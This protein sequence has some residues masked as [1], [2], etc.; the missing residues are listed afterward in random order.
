VVTAVLTGLVVLG[1]ALLGL[2]MRATYGAQVTGDEPQYLL[3]AISLAEDGSLDIDDELDEQRWRDFHE[4]TLPTQTEVLPDGRQLSPHNAGLPALLALP[5]SL[6]GWVGAK[7]A[8][9][10]VFAAAA[11]LAT[12]MAIVRLRVPALPAAIVVAALAASPPLATYATQV[13]P[14]STAAAAVVLALAGLLDPRRRRGAVLAC[15]AVVALPWLSVKYV[16]VAAVVAGVALW[17][18]RHHRRALVAAGGTLLVAGAVYLWFHRATYGGWTPYATGDHF[19]GGEFTVVGVDPDYLDRTQR[20]V[21]LLVDQGFGLVVWQPAYLLLP[22]A[23]AALIAARPP[24]WLPLTV[25]AAAGW[26]TATWLALTMH[27]YWWPGRQVVVVLPAVV[28]AIAWWVGP[29]RRRL[30]T[31]TVLSA[32]G[33]LAFAW[34][35]FETSTGRLTL[36]VDFGAT[37]NPVVR[38]LRAVLPDYMDPGVTMWTLHAVWTTALII[39]AV[40]GYRQGRA[41][42]AG[43]T[44]SDSPTETHDA[45]GARRPLRTSAS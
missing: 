16:P 24:G 27:G 9:A 38:A 34:T 15:V 19:A 4:P 12:W 36:V 42:R 28:L 22:V 3:T 6:G 30:V 40:L 8:M 13:Y 45:P 17:R 37:T 41:R 11:G 21:A 10:V 26:A 39:L 31:A 29:S 32:L 44:A 43:V 25:V 18:V 23:F 33:V 7:A 2:G 35:A 5:V 20:L 14:E 1:V